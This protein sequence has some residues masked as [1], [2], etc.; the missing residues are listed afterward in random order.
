VID[1]FG[2][3]G[4]TG[5]AAASLDRRFILVDQNPES[6]AVMR[7]RFAKAAVPVEFVTN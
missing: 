6:I 3:S 7:E 5:A 1:F 2:G 4:T